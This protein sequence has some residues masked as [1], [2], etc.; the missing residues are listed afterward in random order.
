MSFI[1][2][3]ENVVREYQ[4]ISPQDI[5]DIIIER[6]P[7]YHGTP[8]H[9]ENVE[10]GH[11]QDIGHALLAQI[12]STKKSNRFFVDTTMKPMLISLSE[13]KTINNISLKISSYK[14]PNK[15]KTKRKYKISVDI[16]RPTDNIVDNYLEK[17]NQ[18]E[19]Y[20]TQE[21]A[22]KLLFTSFPENNNIDEILV[23]SSVLN[24][25][26]STNIFKTYFIAKHIA[27]L[28]IQERLDSG[29]LQ[30]VNDI[31]K[32]NINGKCK[33][34]IHDSLANIKQR[35]KRICNTSGV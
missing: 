3:V 32:I 23:K 30:L 13:S 11:Y 7:D 5:R 21:Q 15:S 12:Y 20:K 34:S 25:L 10:K 19:D 29:D 8:T 31:A 6:Y 27:D 16:P 17:W 2:I 18:L 24:D 26:Y 14:S 22:I 1:D 4:P 35:A 33:H 28:K 9:L